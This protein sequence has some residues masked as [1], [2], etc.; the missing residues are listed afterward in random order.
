MIESKP[1]AQFDKNSREQV[2][3]SIDEFKG[4]KLINIRV[5]Y[6]NADV[7]QWLPGKQGI[8]LAVDK[9]SALESALHELSKALKEL[10]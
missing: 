4:R 8:T 5:W 1:I 2:R 9:F 7:E 6:H 3:I 10:I